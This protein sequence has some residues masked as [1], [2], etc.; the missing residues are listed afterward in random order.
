VELDGNRHVVDVR[1]EIQ[2]MHFED[3]NA[4]I[5]CPRPRKPKEKV[6]KARIGPIRN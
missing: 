5:R 1:I 6:D 3:T 2:N 4:T